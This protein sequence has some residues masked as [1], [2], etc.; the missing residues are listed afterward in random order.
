VVV[1]K[2]YRPA[3][4]SDA[5]ILEEHA[6]AAELEQAEVPAV[7]PL[8]S[9]GSTLHHHG[10][11]AFSISP[12]RGGRRPEL[13]DGAVLEWIGRYLARLHIVGAKKPFAERGAIDVATFG[14]EPR[15]WLLAHDAVPLEVQG[16]WTSACET[17]LGMVRSAFAAAGEA[18]V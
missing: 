13:D 18:G 17:A 4:W 6:F 5:Q 3:R 14:E 16:E 15:D 9:Q 10:G 11:F 2:F 1:A 12:R 8:A 7:G